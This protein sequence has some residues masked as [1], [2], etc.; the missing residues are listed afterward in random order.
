MT[1]PGVLAKPAQNP[2]LGRAGPRVSLVV[3]SFGFC[4]TP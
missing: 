1:T 4:V 3:I 2:E